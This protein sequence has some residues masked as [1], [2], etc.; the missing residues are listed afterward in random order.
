MEKENRKEILALGFWLVT[1]CQVFFSSAM[2]GKMKFPRGEKRTYE[3]S[4]VTLQRVH[5]SL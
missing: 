5:V 1:V 4:L 3:W 2:C